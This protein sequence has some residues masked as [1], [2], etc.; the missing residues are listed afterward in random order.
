MFYD[1]YIAPQKQKWYPI[2]SLCV[3]LLEPTLEFLGYFIFFLFIWWETESYIYTLKQDIECLGDHMEQESESNM[4]SFMQSM[5]CFQVFQV[6]SILGVTSVTF[7]FKLYNENHC[8]IGSTTII[9]TI[10]Y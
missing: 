5:K 7:N 6:N 3:L 10:G 4:V 2:L 9:T 8:L 1:D